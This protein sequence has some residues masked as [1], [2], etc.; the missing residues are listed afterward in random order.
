MGKE[1]AGYAR[2]QPRVAGHLGGGVCPPLQP[3][4]HCPGRRAGS[5]HLSRHP[6]EHAAEYRPPQ[7][8]PLEHANH[9]GPTLLKGSF[10]VYFSHIKSSHVKYNKF[11]STFISKYDRLT[12]PF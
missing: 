8:H 11:I 4:H 12:L 1:R 5:R 9:V 10:K 6:A 2:Q 3:A 7:A